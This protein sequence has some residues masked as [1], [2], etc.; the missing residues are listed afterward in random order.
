MRT[1]IR[2]T[3]KELETSSFHPLIEGKLNGQTINLIIDT[4]ASRTVL[5]N[6]LT[7]GAQVIS[8][9][10]EEAFAAGINAERM[11]VKQVKIE[12]IEIDGVE[13]TEMVVFST[14]LDAISNLYE[15][16]A[17]LTIDGLIGCDF[18]LQN[19]AIIDFSSNTISLN[20]EES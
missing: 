19:K 9:E 7:V 2:F 12:R 3:I 10:N 1:T 8:N 20:R 15:E 17:G 14:D 18:L 11:V 13:F 6:K 16:M 4:G 5:S